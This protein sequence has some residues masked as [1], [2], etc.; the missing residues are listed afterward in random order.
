MRGTMPCAASSPGLAP[1]RKKPDRSDVSTL[2]RSSDVKGVIAGTQVLAIS[3]Y[4]S[5]SK[6]IEFRL[7]ARV[8]KPF[9]GAQPKGGIHSA[10][11]E[12][13]AELHIDNAILIEI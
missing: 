2:P 12:K 6:D 7:H 4:Q 10:Q 1:K 8:P 5:D 13:R 3:K 9:S 11:V